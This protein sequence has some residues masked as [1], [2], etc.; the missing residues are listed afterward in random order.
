MELDPNY[1][2]STIAFVFK[3]AF[4]FVSDVHLDYCRCDQDTDADEYQMSL[5]D[6][7]D[8]DDWIELVKYPHIHVVFNSICSFAYGV[9]SPITLG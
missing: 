6:K 1:P 8:D 4:D 3:S 7:S 2:T 9:D 5:F